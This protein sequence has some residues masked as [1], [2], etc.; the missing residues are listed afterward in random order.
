M[1]KHY[2]QCWHVSTKRRHRLSTTMAHPI[3]EGQQWQV[4]QA[5]WASTSEHWVLL[6][7]VR[8]SATAL[9]LGKAA[10]DSS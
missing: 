7:A 10:G 2:Q 9:L 8:I 4:L 3:P 1:N 6:L 5:P